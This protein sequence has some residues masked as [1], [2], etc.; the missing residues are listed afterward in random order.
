VPARRRQRWK[1]ER[2]SAKDRRYRLVA[3]LEMGT[4]LR[5]VSGGLPVGRLSGWPGA[6]VYFAGDVRRAR[7]P[8]RFG[9][10]LLARPFACRRGARLVSPDDHRLMPLRCGADRCAGRARV[11]LGC[12]PDVLRAALGGELQLQHVPADQRPGRLLPPAEVRVAGDTATYLT[13]DRFIRFPFLW[14]R[15]H[16]RDGSAR[17]WKP[18]PQKWV[19]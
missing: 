2:L 8:A 12:S 7:G 5:I 14:R 17:I 10:G 18:K 11:G 9:A 6:F 1:K 13:G 4:G 3:R 15:A 19:L 16:P